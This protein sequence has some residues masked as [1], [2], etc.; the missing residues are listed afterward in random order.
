ML[1]K[2]FNE[3]TA[4][5]E[6]QNGNLSAFGDLYDAYIRKIY[7]FVYY[8]THHKQTAEDLT[9]RV[10]IKALENIS[11]Y[12][13]AK[14]TFS[15]WL[16]RIARNQVIDHYRTVRTSADI[17]DAFDLAG[18]DNVERDLDVKI[19]LEKVSRLLS[20]LTPE[21]RDLVIMR[22]WDGLSYREISH[23]LGKSEDALK[24]SFSRVIGKLRSPASLVLSFLP[25]LSDKI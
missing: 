24:M 5:Q 25:F 7:A 3:E 1:G 23:V 12:S 15:T 13:S 18:K 10:F 11:S 9:S 8:R 19:E 2:Q 21:Q 17:A 14:G 20:E 16:Y 6:C 4:V 22:V